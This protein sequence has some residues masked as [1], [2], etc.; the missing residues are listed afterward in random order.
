MRR[1][2]RPRL[3]QVLWGNAQPAVFKKIGAILARIHEIP[4]SEKEASLSLF[5]RRF[6]DLQMDILHLSVLR[7]E[8]IDVAAKV[9]TT[10]SKKI[11][12]QSKVKFIHGD[13]TIQN[14]FGGNGI[15]V[16]DWEH[17]SSGSSLYDIGVSLS[18]MILL[19]TDGGWS[20]QDYHAGVDCFLEGY[21]GV[22]LL[23][24]EDLRLI[25]GLRFLGHRQVA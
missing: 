13:F 4:S 2:Y 9:I 18:F 7:H 23:S 6:Q 14:M 3:D 1:V 25:D 20:F 21:S 10:I 17:S 19:V 11:L 8:L 24:D 15:V 12:N 5:K 22:R 16:Y